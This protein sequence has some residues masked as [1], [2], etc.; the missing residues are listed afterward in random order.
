MLV[1]TRVVIRK[2]KW[3]AAEAVIKLRALAITKL[4]V[5]RLGRGYVLCPG[6]ADEVEH[7]KGGPFGAPGR[8]VRSRT[9][10]TEGPSPAPLARTTKASTLPGVF[11]WLMRN[12]LQGGLL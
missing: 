2:I 10:F 5:S 8:R 12:Q 3:S 7:M 11:S 6:D 9:R 1:T 4:G